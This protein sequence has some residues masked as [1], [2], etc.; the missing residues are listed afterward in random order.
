MK[1][2]HLEAYFDSLSVAQLDA[3]ER[4][5]EVHISQTCHLRINGRIQSALDRLVLPAPILESLLDVYFFVDPG[6][7]PCQSFQ[8]HCPQPHKPRAQVLRH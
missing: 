3:F 6:R 2:L 4:Q 1:P 7:Y 8:L 5:L